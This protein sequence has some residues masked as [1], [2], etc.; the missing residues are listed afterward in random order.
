MRYWSEMRTK[1]G[2][3]DGDS[4]PDGI[5][6]YRTVYIE[7]LNALAEESGS[8]YRVVPFDR[9][10]MHNFCLILIVKKDTYDDLS[11]IIETTYEDDAIDEILEKAQGMELDAYVEVNVTIR[12]A[13]LTDLL[14]TIYM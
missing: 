11:S 7:V 8:D 14:S 5:E 6:E 3:N 4:I 1:Y 9:S 12:R 2:F 13:E 10:G